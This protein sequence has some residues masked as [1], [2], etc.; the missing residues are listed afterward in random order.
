MKVYYIVKE[1][2]IGEEENIH[3]QSYYTIL[4]EESIRK[5]ESDELWEEWSIEKLAKLAI[6]SLPVAMSLSDLSHT[7]PSF[8]EF[9]A[10]L[11]N[12]AN[13]R[14]NALDG[15]LEILDKLEAEGEPK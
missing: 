8:E 7:K 6:E 15:L 13:K 1:I 2:Y 5:H 10:S 9:I 3:R 12:K 14:K 11:R 4:S